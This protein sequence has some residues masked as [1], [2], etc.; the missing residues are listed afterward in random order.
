MVLQVYC[1]AFPL[2]NVSLNAAQFGIA[3]GAMVGSAIEVGLPL[4]GSMIDCCLGK[5]A[6]AVL[7]REF[8]SPGA[9]SD[10]FRHCA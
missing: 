2:Y 5:G 7:N 8:C 1:I 6:V 3:E 4:H 10:S 9:C